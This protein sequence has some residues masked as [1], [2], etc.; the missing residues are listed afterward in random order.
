MGREAM[1]LGERAS[2]ERRI[3]V[4]GFRWCKD[5]GNILYLQILSGLFEVTWLHGYTVTRLH[6]PKYNYITRM[7]NKLLILLLI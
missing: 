6:L 2:V 4:S 1:G 7:L 3:I 5:K